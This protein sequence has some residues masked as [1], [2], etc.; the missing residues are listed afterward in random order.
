MKKFFKI[1]A[2]VLGLLALMYGEYRYIMTHQAVYTDG[3]TVYI[4]MFNNID[5]YDANEWED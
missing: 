5:V 2:V 1:T 3:N 4:E